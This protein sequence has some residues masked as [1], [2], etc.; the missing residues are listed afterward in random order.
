[1]IM[2][3]KKKIGWWAVPMKIKFTKTG[4]QIIHDPK[5]YGGPILKLKKIGN[6]K[7]CQ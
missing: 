1:M 2:K 3:V 7:V 5:I 6:K 4:F